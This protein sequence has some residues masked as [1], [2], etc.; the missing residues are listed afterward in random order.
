MASTAQP[1]PNLQSDCYVLLENGTKLPVHAPTLAAVSDTLAKTFTFEDQKSISAEAPIR[2]ITSLQEYNSEVVAFVLS[3]LQGRISAVDVPSIRL[4][5]HSCLMVEK[6]NCS[7]ALVKLSAQ[8][9]RLLREK[10]EQHQWMGVP[11]GG[12]KLVAYDLIGIAYFFDNPEEFFNITQDLTM[13][14]R[15]SFCDVSAMMEVV[16]PTV[17]RKYIC[18]FPLHRQD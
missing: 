18:G 10:A 5:K 8:W 16:P 11:I 13:Y 15:G 12:H 14:H 17:F 4:L 6:F 7:H 9:I 2:E 1:P 3:A